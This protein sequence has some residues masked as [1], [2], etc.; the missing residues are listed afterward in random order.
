MHAGLIKRIAKGMLS[1]VGAGSI[2]A[3]FCVNQAL[4]QRFEYSYGGDGCFDAGRG[5]VQQVSAGGYIAVG[6]TFSEKEGGC[7]DANI[8]VVRTHPDGS[9]AWSQAYDLGGNDYGTSIREVSCS[10]NGIGGFIIT[11]YT[12]NGSLCGA[13]RELLL[14]RIDMCG[15]ILWSNTYGTPNGDEQGW[16]VVEACTNGNP[17]YNTRRGDFIAAGFTTATRSGVGRDGY[18]IRVNGLNGALIWDATYDGPNN[19]DDYFYGLDEMRF[20]NPGPTGDIVAA[21]GTSSYTGDYDAWLVRV[22]GDDGTFS[23]GSQGSAAYDGGRAEELRSVKELRFGSAAGDIVAVGRTTSLAGRFDVYALQTTPVPCT[24]RA[25]VVFGDLGGGADEG[26]WIRETPGGELI[27]TGYMTPPAGQGFGNEDAFLCLLRP[28]ILNI[29]GNVMLYG[30]SGTDWGW[31][32][33]PVLSGFN[34]QCITDGFIVAGFTNSRTK[35]ANPADP[36]QMYL[37]KTD[38]NLDDRCGN[39]AYVVAEKHPR[40]QENCKLPTI[41]RLRTWCEGRTWGSCRYWHYQIC[42]DRELPDFCRIERCQDCI[43][44]GSKHTLSGPAEAGSSL[45]LLNSYPNPVKAG[46]TVTLEYM[47]KAD[48]QVRVTVNDLRGRTIYTQER[49]AT[50]GSSSL[51]ISTDGW[52]SGTYMVI[53]TADG[54]STSTR[55]VVTE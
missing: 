30:G 19:Q 51:G 46:G 25:D 11:G 45:L 48:A 35:V 4:A 26:Y 13:A 36:M 9:L 50:L 14:L 21:G 20:N 40:Y 41:N 18:L 22:S 32:V 6:E 37:I 24:L 49:T 34:P 44:D 47:L 43:P 7:G 42:L 27:V 23:G 17:N 5:G 54:R 38:V 1:M 52:A 10:P 53:M 2:L 3:S 29:I 39:R 33:S 55:V 15:T 8:Y 16:D 31:S 28:N 12:D